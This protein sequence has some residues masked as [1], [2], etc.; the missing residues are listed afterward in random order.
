VLEQHLLVLRVVV[1]SVLGNIAELTRDPD[2]LGD[3][4]A[5]RF[6]ASASRSPQV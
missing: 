1:L 3:L 2:P 5:L 4:A 6:R